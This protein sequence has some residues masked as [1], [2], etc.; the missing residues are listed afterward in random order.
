MPANP[1]RPPNTKPIKWFLFSTEEI[2]SLDRA[3]QAI[4]EYARRWRI[5]GPQIRLPPGDYRTLARGA[6]LF[7]NYDSG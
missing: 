4:R 7:I 5:H 2:D 3:T 6:A 1:I